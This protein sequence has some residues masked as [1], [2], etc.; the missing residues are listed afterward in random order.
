[1]R[2]RSLH[3]VNRSSLPVRRLSNVTWRTE[4]ERNRGTR[5]RP[6][7]AQANDRFSRRAAS[8]W[9]DARRWQ[10]I[11]SADEAICWSVV[12]PVVPARESA[13]AAHAAALRLRVGGGGARARHSTGGFWRLAISP[14][15]RRSRYLVLR[16]SHMSARRSRLRRNACGCRPLSI[17]RPAHPTGRR[18]PRERRRRARA[19]ALPRR[20]R[21]VTHV[22]SCE[23][24]RSGAPAVSR[25][26]KSD[27][28][29][30]STRGFS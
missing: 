11:F 14:P 2:T 27:S 1:M 3:S 6:L 23:L 26:L 22:V 20:G 25:L 30:S 17:V 15:T 28:F 24:I 12:D 7:V 9:L 21:F 10:N 4:R 19:S 18:R 8:M 29:S 16:I 5:K 13:D